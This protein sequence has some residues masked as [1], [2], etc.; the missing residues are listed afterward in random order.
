MPFAKIVF[1][2]IQRWFGIIAPIVSEDVPEDI[3]DISTD[4]IFKNGVFG[5]DNAEN[6]N[7]LV[8]NIARKSKYPKFAMIKSALQIIFP[9]YK[10]MVVSEEYQFIKKIPIILPF[11][12]VYH[13]FRYIRKRGFNNA[14]KQISKSFVTKDYISQREEM[15]RNWGV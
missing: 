3:F 10:V 9:S 15:F 1:Y 7:Y 13:I 6:K 11:A 2:Y 8:S 5:F 12:W 4:Y 14:R